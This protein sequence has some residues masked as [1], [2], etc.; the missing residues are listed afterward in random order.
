MVS[1]LEESGFLDSSQHGS[2]PGRSTLTQLLQQYEHV[3]DLLGRGLNVEVCYLDF[4]KAFDKVDLGLL[5]K[6]LHLLGIRGSLGSWISNFILNR[7]QAVK[8]GPVISSWSLVQSGV[9]QGSVLGP[10]LFLVF[11]GDLGTNIPKDEAMVLKYVDDTKII[12]GVSKEEDV[13]SFQDTLQKV[14][15]WQKENNMKFNDKKFQILRMGSDMDLIEGTALFTEGFEEMIH[16]EEYVKDLGVMVDVGGNFHTQRLS[17]ASKARSKAAWVLRTFKTRDLFFMRTLL[18][19]LILP[20][21]DYCS[22]LWFPS[23]SGLELRN[24]EATQKSFTKKIRGLSH[25]HYWTRLNRMGLRSTERRME[26]YK[27]MYLYKVLIGEVPNFGVYVN[28]ISSRRGRLF[29]IPDHR[30]KYSYVTTLKERSL[31]VEGPRLFNSLPSVLRSF[32]GSKERFKSLLDLYLYSVPD[33]PNGRSMFS[34]AV[35]RLGSP[36]NSLKDWSRLLKVKDW[37]PPAE[38]F[39]FKLNEVINYDSLLPAEV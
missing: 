15:T 7:R 12:K 24:L 13:L 17:A 35:T 28:E 11:I 20:H 39:I 21:L 36:S 14:Y 22:Q 31:N 27:V 10:L 18:K 1:F 2:R 29:I 3:L 32:N 25:L 9:P 19:S 8:V 4:S 16:P 34:S 6:K 30:S 5:I 38:K 37:Y 33:K 26:R 23:S